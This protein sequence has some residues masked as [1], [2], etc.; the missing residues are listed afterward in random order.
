MLP[1]SHASSTFPTILEGS[2]RKADN[3]VRISAQLIDAHDGFNLWS[4]TYDRQ[5]DDIFAVQNDIARAVAEA[6]EVELLGGETASASGGTSAE[7]YNAYL[8]G[9]YFTFRENEDDILRAIGYY[10]EALAL[11]SDYAPA[12]AGMAIAYVILAAKGTADF[13]A[14]PL[15][16]GMAKARQAAERALKLDDT[17]AAAHL[18]LAGIQKNYEWDWA[19][20]AV[21]MEQAMELAPNDAFVVFRSAVTKATLGH[22]GRSSRAEPPGDRAR[23]AQQLRAQ[24]ARTLCLERRSPGRGRG[25]VGKVSGAQPGRR[26]DPFVPTPR[27]SRPVAGRKKCCEDWNKSPPRLPGVCATSR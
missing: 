10:K 8:Q 18:A 19:G 12:W 3:R 21:S 25:G 11:D 14:I 5:L 1:R 26:R 23:S 13:A 9:R 2:V 4:A 20:A 15:H 17:L 24:P 16:E 7:A 22:F 6:L 27:Q